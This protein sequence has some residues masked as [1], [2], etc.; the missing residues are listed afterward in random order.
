MSDLLRKFV[1]N[2]DNRTLMNAVDAV[3]YARPLPNREFDQI[4]MLAFDM[5]AQAKHVAKQIAGK[6]V[7]FL[8]DGDG[9]SILFARLQSVGLMDEVASMQ[10]CDFDERI[11]T[12]VKHL[13]EECSSGNF[14]ASTTLYNIINPT[15]DELV[16][17]FDFFYINPPYGSKNGGLSCELWLHR[18][19]DLCAPKCGGCIIIPYS[20]TQSWTVSNWKNIQKFLL[21]KGFVVRDMVANKHSYYLPDNPDLQ[22]ASI[23]VEQINDGTSEYHSKMFDKNQTRNLYGSPRAMPQYIFESSTN[24]LGDRDYNWEYGEDGFWD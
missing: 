1:Q 18:C 24:L 4:Y 11:L 2:E 13:I 19:L 22:S 15:P 16:G 23:I 9:M 7:V 17:K 8:G 3:S 20:K 21:E 10:V 14:V 5:M 6:N 12:T